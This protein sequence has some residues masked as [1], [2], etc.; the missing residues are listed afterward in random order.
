MVKDQTPVSL[1]PRALAIRLELL[2]ATRLLEAS[3]VDVSSA[4]ATPPS[5]QTTDQRGTTLATMPVPVWA[6]L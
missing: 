5:D 2:N 3:D 4:A 1:M 6:S